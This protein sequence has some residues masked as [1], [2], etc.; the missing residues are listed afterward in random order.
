MYDR[1]FCKYLCPAGA[2]YGIVGKVSPMKVK[3]NDNLCVN[4]DK[5]SKVC[6][7]NIDVANTKYVNTAECIN[8]NICITSCPKKNALEVKYGNISLTPSIAIVLIIFLFFGSIF[9]SDASGIY[10]VIPDRIAAGETISL[11]EI[12]GYMTIEEASEAV[13]LS[14]GEFYDLY[15]IPTSV[16]SNV[17]MKDIKKVVPSYNF[18]QVKETLAR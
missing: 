14:L 15:K 13:G 6:P 7:V 17:K 8:C 16:A 2:F 11:I 4:C 10:K 3:R 12:K 18:D 9:I 1:F 5:C